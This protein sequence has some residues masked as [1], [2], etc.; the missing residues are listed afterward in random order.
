MEWGTEIRAGITSASPPPGCPV[1]GAASLAPDSGFQ[2]TGTADF[3]AIAVA[4]PGNRG[5]PTA[6]IT[7]ACFSYVPVNCAA[8]TA[9]DRS[10]TFHLDRSHRHHIVD[11]MC[12]GTETAPIGQYP[13]VIWRY[14]P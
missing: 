8:I 11:V 10:I 4:P 14:A 1:Q 6:P 2:A 9:L 7:E 13:R 3:L 12:H 5:M